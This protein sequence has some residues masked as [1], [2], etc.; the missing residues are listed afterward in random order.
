MFIL[1]EKFFCFVMEV[2]IKFF[3]LFCKG[4][5]F[6]V[7]LSKIENF[8][9]G[10][11]KLKFVIFVCK[12][13]LIEIFV[14]DNDKKL[15]INVD[16]LDIDIEREIFEEYLRRFRCDNVSENLVIK[17]KCFFIKGSFR[18]DDGFWL[19]FFLG[20]FNDD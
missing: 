11:V 3:L 13:S 6:E 8:K 12:G 9:D 2:D 10:F 5:Y 17:L 14:K 4:C 19:I 1:G 18:F 15:F 7:N 20:K 16:L